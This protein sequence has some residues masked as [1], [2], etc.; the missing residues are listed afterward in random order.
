MAP[1]CVAF[2]NPITFMMASE[3]GSSNTPLV[4]PVAVKF[5]AVGFVRSNYTLF[6]VS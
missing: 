2:L 3:M 5:S 4:L 1:G 6:G